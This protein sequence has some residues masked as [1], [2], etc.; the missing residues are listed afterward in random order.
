MGR[1]LL[2]RIVLPTIGILRW[3]LRN[4]PTPGSRPGPLPFYQ[5]LLLLFVAGGLL[6]AIGTILFERAGNMMAWSSLLGDLII[7][8]L[9]VWQWRQSDGAKRTIFACIMIGAALF[10]CSDLLTLGKLF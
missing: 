7:L 9:A 4:I 1:I 5:Y 2:L 8:T 10:L 6:G 3:L